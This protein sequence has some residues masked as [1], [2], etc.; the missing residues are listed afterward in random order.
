MKEQPK[1]YEKK[2][3]YRNHSPV[4]GNN[5]ELPVSIRICHRKSWA[6]IA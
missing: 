4:M 5:T 3:Y 6:I 2:M 1:E